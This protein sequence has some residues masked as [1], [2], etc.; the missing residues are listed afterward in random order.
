MGPFRY[1]CLLTMLM[2]IGLPGQAQDLPATVHKRTYGLYASA[3]ATA[4]QSQ[5]FESTNAVIQTS[6]GPLLP[7][8]GL[9]L[10]YSHS[11]TLS[12][13]TGLLFLRAGYGFR[14]QVEQVGISRAYLHNYTQVPLSVVLRLWQPTPR[15]ALH[16]VAGGVVSFLSPQNYPLLVDTLGY[17]NGLRTVPNQRIF[18]TA[19]GKTPGAR[20]TAALGLRAE[21]QASP[22]LLI[23]GEVK[24]MVAL[25]GLNEN[26]ISVVDEATHN[27][28]ATAHTDLRLNTLSAAITVRYVFLTGTKYR[29]QPEQ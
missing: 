29:Y 14:V 7:V 18:L 13:E 27:V 16:V 5:R 19:Q 8:W 24:N 23:G 26:V 11:P 21:W 25:S 28:L 9:H 4:L 6:K 17:Q 15:I 3:V 20:Y 1:T 12:F 10:G 2:G 22:M